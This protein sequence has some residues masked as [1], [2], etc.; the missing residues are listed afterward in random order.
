MRERRSYLTVVGAIAAADHKLVGEEVSMLRRL[1]R[2]LKLT[3]RATGEVIANAEQPTPEILEAA[4]RNLKSSQLRFTLLTD[5]IFMAYAD[6]V[7]VPQEEEAIKGIA[8]AFGISAEQLFSLRE[9]VEAVRAASASPRRTAAVDKALEEAV[10]GVAGA[11]VPL[12]AVALSG[13]VVGFSAAGMTSG[14]SALG[15]GLGMASGMGVA[16]GMGIGSYIGVKWLWKRMA[17]S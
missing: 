5:C 2:V 4:I 8:C 7:V 14:L 17:K 12:A 10:A 13:Q 9:Y 15:M 16:V 3:P 6:E 11:G 1:C